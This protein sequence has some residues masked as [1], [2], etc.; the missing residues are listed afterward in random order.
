MRVTEQ[1]NAEQ[2]IKIFAESAK[3]NQ[4]IGTAILKKQQDVEK[5]TANAVLELLQSAA[6]LPDSG[7]R[8]D[9]KA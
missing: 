8:F 1:S 9:A 6:N 7:S 4:D 3:T 2:L 5:G